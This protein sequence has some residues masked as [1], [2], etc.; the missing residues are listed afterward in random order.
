LPAGRGRT[1]QQFSYTLTP[2]Q[3]TTVVMLGIVAGKRCW[4]VIV[5]RGWLGLMGMSRKGEAV[6]IIKTQ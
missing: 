2:P 1:N 3:M 4:L 5:E 6:E